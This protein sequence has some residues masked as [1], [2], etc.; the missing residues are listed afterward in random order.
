MAVKLLAGWLAWRSSL[1]VRP[2]T[3]ELRQP[4]C[5]SG[6]GCCARGDLL[7]GLRS[8]PQDQTL[9]VVLASGR[10]PAVAL[11]AVVGCRCP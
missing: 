4:R 5:A 8:E 9:C 1:V 6:I 3:G 2:V 11:L 10:V 7:P